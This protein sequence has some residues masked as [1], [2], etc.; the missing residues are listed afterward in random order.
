M[1]QLTNAE[2]IVAHNVAQGFAEKEI[3]DRL[4]VSVHTIHTHARNIR[5]K[6]NARNIADVTRIYILSLE[7]PKLVLKAVLCLTIHIGVALYEADSD[8]RK[9]LRSKLAKSVRSARS[10][11]KT[12]VYYA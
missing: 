7:N 8:L 9:P 5:R 12:G 6:W 11:V 4:C 1:N 10:R 3:A 2:T